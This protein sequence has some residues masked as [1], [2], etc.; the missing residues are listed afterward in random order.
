MNKRK[1]IK[2]HKCKFARGFVMEDYL[3]WECVYGCGEQELEHF[4]EMNDD[5]WKWVKEY[6][7]RDRRDDD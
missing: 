1:E 7:Q 5:S 6:F 2:P 3:I 4:S